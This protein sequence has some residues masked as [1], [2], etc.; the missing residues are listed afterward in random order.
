MPRFFLDPTAWGADAALTG[1]E[2][3]HCARV[4][5][6]QVGD[7][8]TVFDGLGRSAVAEILN[9]SKSHVGL[10]LGE[11]R[12]ESAPK[13]RVVLAQA[14]IKGK[15]MDWLLQKA[16]E[17]GV[18]DIQPLSTRN[19]VVQAGEGKEEKWQRAVIEACKQCG[20]S[21]VPTVLPIL[22]L[23]PFL[24]KSATS[25]RLIASLEENARPLKEC[26]SEAGEGGELIFLVGPE[27]DFSP[28]EYAAA[29]ESGCLP[30]SLGTAVLRSETAGIY[31]LSAAA[32]AFS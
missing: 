9:V 3:K 17:L 6:A 4:M 1:D 7:S 25:S 31:C 10:H 29:R 24:E 26:L 19:A 18:T 32:Y 8:I 20:R 5:R 14:V 30:V 15:A 23:E 2:A 28:T 21:R 27:G 12:H 11:A 16:V 13:V 22:E